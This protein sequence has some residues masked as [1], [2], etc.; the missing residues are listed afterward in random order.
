VSFYIIRMVASS[1]DES[2]R[3]APTL[4]RSHP[5]R[6]YF[7]SVAG[8]NISDESSLERLNYQWNPLSVVS[9]F[10]KMG[11]KGCGYSSEPI[12][13]RKSQRTF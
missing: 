8:K 7:Y 9:I 6:L 2:G 5:C 11:S 13:R 4:T 12:L 3:P 1:P 10:K